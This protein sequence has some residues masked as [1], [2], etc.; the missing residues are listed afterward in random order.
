MGKIRREVE[1]AGDRFALFGPTIGRRP[2]LCFCALVDTRARIGG[3]YT[4]FVWADAAPQGAPIRA[5]FQ[6]CLNPP[7]PAPFVSSSQ[8]RLR[9]RVSTSLD[10]KAG[11]LYVTRP[12]LRFLID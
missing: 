11:M 2:M 7:R 12:E 8:L 1:A 6:G 5:S 9:Q 10:T 3:T 4:E